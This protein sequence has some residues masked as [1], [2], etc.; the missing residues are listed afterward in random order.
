MDPSSI[1][2]ETQLLD[3]TQELSTSDKLGKVLAAI[4]HS[5]VSMETRLG[6]LAIEL[7]F[8]HADHRKLRDKVSDGE[9][10][11]AALQPLA[12]D[13]LKA[14]RDL[15]ECVRLLEDRAEDAKE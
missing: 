12:T 1:I 15:Q 11:L 5:R 14:T 8:L 6:S 7:S 3:A 13:N 2:T 9:K 10:T 4:E